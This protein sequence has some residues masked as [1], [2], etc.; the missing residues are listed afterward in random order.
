MTDQ[1]AVGEIVELLGLESPKVLWAYRPIVNCHLTTFWTW[2]SQSCLHMSSKIISE[3]SSLQN[4]INHIIS[5]HPQLFTWGFTRI[6]WSRWLLHGI[7]STSQQGLLRFEAQFAETVDH[8]GDLL[9]LDPIVMT[10]EVRE[11]PTC[12]GLKE[13]LLKVPGQL[14]MNCS[15]EVTMSIYSRKYLKLDLLRLSD[16]SGHPS[17]SSTIYKKKWTDNMIRWKDMMCMEVWAFSYLCSVSLKRLACSK[18][19]R[20][21]LWVEPGK[22]PIY[23]TFWTWGQ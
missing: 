16:F 23:A 17:T 14:G 7:L 10:A 9:R 19:F 4:L 6:H 8:V 12:H 11:E 18:V 21:W 13:V 22:P 15:H 3:E 1:A 2:W 20:L 5:A